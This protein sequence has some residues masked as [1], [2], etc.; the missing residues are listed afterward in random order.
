MRSVGCALLCLGLWSLAT[1]AAALEDYADAIAQELALDDKP[2][3]GYCHARNDEGRATD[4]PFGDA[5]KARGFTRRMGVRSLLDALRLLEADGTDTD[6]DGV[7]DI[8]EL[9]AYANPNDPSDNGLPSTAGCSLTPL[10]PSTASAFTPSWLLL[11]AVVTHRLRRR[12]TTTRART[13]G[14]D[15]SR[16]VGR[17]RSR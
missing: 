7:T 16:R 12:S 13:R 17:G 5:L 10:A 11:G 6:G 1:N 4:T 8:D 3:C 15:G 9:T 2:A 14:A